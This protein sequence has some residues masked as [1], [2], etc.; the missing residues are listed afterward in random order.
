MKV[1]KNKTTQGD[2]DM[3]NA[4]KALR[5]KITFLLRKVNER[6]A[7]EVINKLNSFNKKIIS[8]MEFNLIK[9][10][11]RD[12]YYYFG[13]NNRIDDMRGIYQDTSDIQKNQIKTSNIIKNNLSDDELEMLR[14]DINYFIKDPLIKENVNFLKSK[15]LIDILKDEDKANE[16]RKLRESLMTRKSNKSV[17]KELEMTRTSMKDVLIKSERTVVV[18]NNFKPSSQIPLTQ[19]DVRLCEA[20]KHI[21]PIIKNKQEKI[22]EDK[23]F[24]QE[25]KKK[26]IRMLVNMT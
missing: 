22:D 21:M 3:T 18:N 24:R 1:L 9:D 6:Q 23:K 19:F 17:V 7:D 14:K 5:T 4:K 20:K 11:D 16:K 13:K 10:V 26:P 15:K 2:L 25:D 8:S 12:P